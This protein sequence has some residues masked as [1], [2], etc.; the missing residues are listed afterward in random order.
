MNETKD[1]MQGFREQHDKKDEHDLAPNQVWKH[2]SMYKWYRITRINMPGFA[3]WDGGAPSL[4][5]ERVLPCD[6]EQRPAYQLPD[7]E[8][9][10]KQYAEMYSSYE[11]ARE[12]YNEKYK[13]VA[14]V[15]NPGESGLYDSHRSQPID[16]ER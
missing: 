3:D 6:S 12:H 11:E 2:K 15:D 16:E 4:G 10:A 14:H 5:V 1:V 9:D 8:E 7:E 13:C